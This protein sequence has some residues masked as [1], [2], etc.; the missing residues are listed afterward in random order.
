LLNPQLTLTQHQPLV[1]HR[2]DTEKRNESKLY[3]F[4]DV[5]SALMCRLDDVFMKNH[6]IE[7]QFA[8]W[9]TDIC[10]TDLSPLSAVTSF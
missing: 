9:K 10:V 3:L 1:N 7:Q 8:L 6:K 4:S 5:L 2:F